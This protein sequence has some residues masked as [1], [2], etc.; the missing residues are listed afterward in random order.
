MYQYHKQLHIGGTIVQAF[1]EISGKFSQRMNFHLTK[2]A[3]K[4]K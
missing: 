1:L 3:L 4:P 2:Y